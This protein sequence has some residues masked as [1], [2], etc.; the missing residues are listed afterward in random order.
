MGYMS[1]LHFQIFEEPHL[2]SECSL[3]EEKDPAVLFGEYQTEARR[4]EVQKK[5]LFVR[6]RCARAAKS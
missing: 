5:E 4:S 3:E 1:R 6:E 2:E